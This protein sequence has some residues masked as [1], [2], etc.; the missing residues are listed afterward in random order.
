[1]DVVLHDADG[2]V[3]IGAGAAVPVVMGC[4]VKQRVLLLV[5]VKEERFLGGRRLLLEGGAE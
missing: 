1:V 2:G 4:A 3:V 5:R